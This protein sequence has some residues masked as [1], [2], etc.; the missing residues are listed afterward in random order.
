ME[1]ISSWFKQGLGARIDALQLAVRDLE[2]NHA[3]AEDTLKRLAFSVS[4]P[5]TSQGL[6]AVCEAA[7]PVRSSD[8][9]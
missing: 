8:R 3:D 7:E 1:H 9:A 4:A 6:D 5:A 2:S